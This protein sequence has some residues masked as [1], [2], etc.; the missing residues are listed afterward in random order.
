MEKIKIEY[1]KLKLI[2]EQQQ[3]SKILSPQKQEALVVDSKGD[4]ADEI[5]ANMIVE[6][7]SQLSNRASIK[8]SM[9]RDALEKIESNEY[10]NCEDCGE[11]I[12]EKRLEINPCFKV[13]ITCAEERE[14]EAKQRIQK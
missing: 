2:N 7:D 9:I 1:F 4:E 10:G 8:L 3:L 12:P 11:E 5:Q 14:F 6:M 13:C